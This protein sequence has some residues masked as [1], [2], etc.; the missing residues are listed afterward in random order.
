MRK[1]NKFRFVSKF[2]VY[3]YFFQNRI[4]RFKRPKWVLAQKKIL[5]LESQ[6]KS[7]KASS[8]LKK[9]FFK[10]HKAKIQKANILKSLF[11][12]FVTI[13]S[14]VNS[15]QRLRFFYKEALL[16]K[17]IIRKY[18]DGRFS[19]AYFKKLFKKTKKSFV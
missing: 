8:Q 12:N 2:Y 6:I 15:W 3:P 19:L 1:Y 18:F 5:R 11:F 10:F 9:K 13:K 14:K 7:L 17:N 4:L 16:I